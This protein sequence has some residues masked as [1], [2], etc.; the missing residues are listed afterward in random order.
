[1]KVVFIIEKINYF[2]N[3]STLINQF[4]INNDQVVFFYSKKINE[5]LLNK[6]ILRLNLKISNEDLVEFK[7]LDEIN[8]LV[9]KFKDVNFYISLHPIN[10]KVDAE[11]LKFLSKKWCVI[12]HGDDSFMTVWDWNGF[13]F[14]IDISELYHRNFFI[15]NKK[16]FEWHLKIIRDNPF[17]K[18]Q[19]KNYEFF[20]NN[21]TKLFEI[22]DNQIDE[23][24]KNSKIENFYKRFG[25]SK[26]QKII[27]YLP[28][29]Y[30]PP[31]N[32]VTKNYSW[33]AAYSGI[34]CDLY[35]NKLWTTKKNFI[36]VFFYSIFLKIKIFFFVINNSNSRNLY[37]NNINEKTIL[38]KIA[39]FCK[40]N[41]FKLAVKSR[42]KFPIIRNINKYADY[43]IDDEEDYFYPSLFQESILASEFVIGYFSTAVREVI[44]L[45][46][47]YVNIQPDNDF[48]DNR[49]DRLLR[50]ETINYSRY[51]YPG[52]VKN[53]K[54]REFISNFDKLKKSFFKINHENLYK[55]KSIFLGINKNIIGSKL[56]YNLL[57]KLKEN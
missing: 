49:K 26:N 1:M 13:N 17:N 9:K 6:Q 30:N 51:N 39:L 18:F 27:L 54:L 31:R 46:K 38:K 7:K 45:D 8:S 5:D 2:R 12:M 23:N 48:F 42:K 10:F 28:F 14:D 33:Q 25:I 55:Y 15:F 16:M 36:L 22:G 50:F 34:Y 44:A 47:M 4:V 3:F 19:E 52:V 41:N 24:I 40:K 35:S 29:P 57:K 32:N 11:V 53:F 37:F 43:F 56:F 21:Y 20:N